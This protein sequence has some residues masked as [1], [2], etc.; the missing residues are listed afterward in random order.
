MV[1][2]RRRS[3][4]VGVDL[5]SEFIELGYELFR[6][7]ETYAGRFVV[8][9][10][11]DDGPNTAMSALCGK[12]DFIHIAAFLHLFGWEG[13]IEAA[14][15]IIAFLKDKPGT[16]ILGRQ[17]GSQEPGEFKHPASAKGVVCSHDETTFRRMWDEVEERTGTRWRLELRLK[18]KV[19]TSP[20]GVDMLYFEGTRV[21]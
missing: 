8:G 19:G 17:R 16:M 13:Q 5:R 2:L 12:A 15:R 7:R 1:R 18:L 10:I 9:D 20:A 4:A 3:W 6:D 21:A 11:F 14:V